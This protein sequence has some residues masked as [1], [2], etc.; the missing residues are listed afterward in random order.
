MNIF[1]EKERL[2]KL[3]YMHGSPVKRGLVASSGQWRWF[4]FRFY[5]VEGAS[6]LR[7]DRID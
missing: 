3:R 6:V 5:H 2:E 7:M 1:T 4:S